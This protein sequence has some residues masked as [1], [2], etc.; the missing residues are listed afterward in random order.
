MEWKENEIYPG[1]HWML[2]NRHGDYIARIDKRQYDNLF[3]WTI[4]PY[5][6]EKRMYGYAKTLDKAKQLVEAILNG[7]PIQLTLNLEG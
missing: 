6:D 2:Y 1:R 7:N 4:Y 5:N 3:R